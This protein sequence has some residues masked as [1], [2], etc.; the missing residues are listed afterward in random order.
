MSYR[1][2]IEPQD[3]NV[4]DSSVSPSL[5]GSVCNDALWYLF[6]YMYIMWHI[7]KYIVT[8]FIA[9]LNSKCIC[10]SAG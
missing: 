1:G 10:G 6:L 4:F 2:H 9:L 7:E 8:I 5:S 3:F